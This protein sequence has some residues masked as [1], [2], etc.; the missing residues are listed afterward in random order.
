MS[1]GSIGGCGEALRPRDQFAPGDVVR[2]TDGATLS[3]TLGA[4][5]I[6]SS[7]FRGQRRGEPAGKIFQGRQGNGAA[8][9][10]SDPPTGLRFRSG[11]QGGGAAVVRALPQGRGKGE[12]RE[13]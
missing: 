11:G 1:I 9:S 10:K 6:G 8:G 4:F 7:S 5:P 2:Q 13:R 12:V 3:G